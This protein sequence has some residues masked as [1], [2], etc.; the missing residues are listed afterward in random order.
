MVLLGGAELWPVVPV[1]GQLL[2]PHTQPPSAY[3]V[4]TRIRSGAD[5]DAL[6]GGA[7]LCELHGDTDQSS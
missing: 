7:S 4:P 5:T 3:C 2:P 1:V 6:L